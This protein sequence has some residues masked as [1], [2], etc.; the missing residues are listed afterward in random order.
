MVHLYINCIFD[1]CKRNSKVPHFQGYD[2]LSPYLKMLSIMHSISQEFK[3]FPTSSFHM[4]KQ[5]SH[6]SFL[7]VKSSNHFA[8]LPIAKIMG[9]SPC[10]PAMDVSALQETP[11]QQ[12]SLAILMGDPSPLNNLQETPKPCLPYW[13]IPGPTGLGRDPRS[14]LLCTLH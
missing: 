7:L 1:G 11:N 13:G 14:P 9:C 8:M 5:F 2:S 12:G 4:F 3:Y 6:Q 10:R